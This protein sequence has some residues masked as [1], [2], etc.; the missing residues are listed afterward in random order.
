MPARRTEI[1]AHVIR[2]HSP[3]IKSDLRHFQKAPPKNI[4]FDT[5]KAGKHD[6]CLPACMDSGIPL[7]A[8]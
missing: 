4:P 7:T 8:G 1:S 6:L 5:P 2:F 3:A